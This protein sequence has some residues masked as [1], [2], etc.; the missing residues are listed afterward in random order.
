MTSYIIVGAKFRPPAKGLLDTLANGTKLHARR[1]ASN[2]Y[3]PNAI[4]VVL[5]AG[6]FETNDEMRLACEGFGLSISDIKAAP[7]WHLGYIPREHAA[8]LAPR[9]DSASTP[10]LDG[11]LSF[12]VTGIP[13][14]RLDKEP[15]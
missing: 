12:S 6:D 1:E 2:A 13:S 3:D 9:M 7:E 5:K 8:E 4:Q 15:T 10:E 14:I 11:V